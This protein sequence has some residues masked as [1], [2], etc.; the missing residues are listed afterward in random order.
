MS[1][2]SKWNNI[3]HRKAKGDAVRG[4]IFTKIGREIAV[5]V[6]S[7]GS[8]P[9]S[10]SRLWDIIAKAR[11]NNM[12]NDN[13]TRS[14]KKAAGELG[15]INYEEV[16]YEGYGV[17]GVAV[18]VECLTDNKNRTAGDIRHLFDKSGGAMGTAGCVSFMFDLKGIVAVN[19]K[20]GLDDD[21]M[22]MAALDL[23]AD[24]FNSSDGQYEILCPPA[25]VS[26]VRKGF[27]N[28]GMI[29]ESAETQRV[30]Q[31]TVSLDAETAEKIQKM[32]E[33]F[34]DNDDVQE[35]YHN[36]ELPEDENDE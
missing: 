20:D 3:K 24:D 26:A 17:G 33:R 18:I 5:A 4:K 32:I 30:P 28:L 9:A 27:E 25:A 2:H 12:P 23:G 8:D 16:V 1:G 10:N 13:I 29:V 34:D 22:M 6:K 21:E 31:N 35:V 36:A 7:G 19:K 15:N 11:A 14:I